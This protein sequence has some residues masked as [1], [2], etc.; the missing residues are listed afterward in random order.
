[1]LYGA[2][3]PYDTNSFDRDDTNDGTSSN[4]G[5]SGSGTS[6]NTGSYSSDASSDNSNK[7]WIYD[8]YWYSVSPLA[9][10]LI[11]IFSWFGLWFII[12]LMES[13]FQF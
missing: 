11:V 13:R 3:C 4:S 9:V 5:S 1:M 2:G 8:D 6:Y 7:D 12:G 10:I